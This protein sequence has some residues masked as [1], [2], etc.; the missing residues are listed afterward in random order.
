[1]RDTAFKNKENKQKLDDIMHPAI[2]QTTL[3]QIHKYELQKNKYCIIVV[4]LLIETGFIKL[5]DRVLIVI[6]PLEQKLT[7]LKKR[8]QLNPEEAAQIMAA[9]TTDDEKLAVPDDVIYNDSDIVTVQS[10]VQQLH[11]QYLTLAH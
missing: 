6:A 4:P 5:V 11:Q 10:K 7:W 2:R 3:Q 9:Q 1:M 8:S